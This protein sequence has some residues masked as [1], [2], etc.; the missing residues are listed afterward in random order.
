M[1]FRFLTF[2]SIVP[3]KLSVYPQTNSSLTLPF[4]TLIQFTHEVII[5]SDRQSI[6]SNM[7][8]ESLKEARE[9][10]VRCYALASA[11]VRVQ[12]YQLP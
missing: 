3:T 5:A 1:A 10:A 2:T 9:D 4:K 7:C 11:N 6:R 8:L 12:I